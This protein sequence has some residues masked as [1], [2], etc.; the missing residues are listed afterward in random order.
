[1]SYQSDAYNILIVQVKKLH[2]H[3]RR[4]TRHGCTDRAI[5]GYM[6]IVQTKVQKFIYKLLDEGECEKNFQE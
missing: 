6:P 4:C 5:H 1:M 3:K 2:G